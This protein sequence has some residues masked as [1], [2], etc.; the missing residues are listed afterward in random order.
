MN[1][2]SELI[3]QTLNELGCIENLS[4]A[5][6]GIGYEYGGDDA[7]GTAVAQTLIEKYSLEIN[8][9]FLIINSGVA[10]ENFTGT[11]RR[12]KPDVVIL[13]D[14][15][16]MDEEPGTIQWLNWRDTSGMA[17]VTHSL[18]PYM[19]AQYLSAEVGC[20]VYLLGIQPATN[21]FG[22]V[23]SQEVAQAVGEISQTLANLVIIPGQCHYNR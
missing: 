21:Q 13:V 2:W 8:Q 15:A 10:P 16:Q 1:T 7:A 5:I 3:T 20:E 12:F 19:L 6:V 9:R 17:S 11:L 4:I 18:P 23:M 14:S 22:S